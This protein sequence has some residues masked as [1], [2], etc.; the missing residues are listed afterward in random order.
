VGEPARPTGDP[1]G[2][3]DVDDVVELVAQVQQLLDHQ[4]RRV[5]VHPDG[6]LEV[7]EVD[8]VDRCRRGEPGI[9]DQHVDLA[10][11]GHHLR[12]Q[13]GDRVPVVQVDGVAGDRL[14]VRVVGP[15][16]RLGL[17]DLV[18]LPGLQDYVGYDIVAPQ[19][20]FVGGQFVYSP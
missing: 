5:Q 12:H 2:G 9:V 1:G 4:E 3:G 7:G 17:G 20:T 10:V 18:G 8:L 16:L 15:H 6:A 14:A 13:P 19:E 11:G